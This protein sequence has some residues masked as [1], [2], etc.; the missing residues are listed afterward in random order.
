MKGIVS[1][2]IDMTLLNHADY[3]VPDSAMRAIEQLR[4]NY[5]VVLATGRDL[6]TSYS[7]GYREM[8]N[9]DAIIHLNG[10]KVEVGGEVIASHF[11]DRNLVERVLHFAEGKSFAV[12]LTAGSED[13]FVNPEYVTIHDMRRWGSSD[14]RFR[15]P[16]KLMEMEV[17]TMTYIGSEE[18]RKQVEE[19][20]PELRLPPFSSRE[21][22][23]MI[24]LGSSKA[25]G[26]GRLCTYFDIPI[27]KTV[28]FG[29][30][31]NDM[32]IIEAAGIGVAMGN[33]DEELKAVADYVTTAIG[34]DGVWNACVNLGL[35]EGTNREEEDG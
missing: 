23:D 27:E 14:R 7:A 34:D 30:S 6:D 18:G 31:M 10:T 25:V 8:F 13:Y 35:I 24:E 20:F 16:W 26:L 2:D 11:M 33:A 3:R 32:E 28:A 17:R 22:A 21:G 29:D 9:P 4:K 5:Y 1:F 12:G 19:A 15:N